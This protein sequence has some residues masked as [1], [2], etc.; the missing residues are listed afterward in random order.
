MDRQSKHVSSEERGVILAEHERGNS[1]RGACMTN[2][3]RAA[4]V[5]ADWSRAAPCIGLFTITLFITAG[6]PSR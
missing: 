2:A 5:V 6:L 3:E 4:D 1:Q